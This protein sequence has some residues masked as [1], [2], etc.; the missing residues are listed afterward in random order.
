MSSWIPRLTGAWHWHTTRTYSPHFLSLCDRFILH[1][2]EGS[3]WPLSKFSSFLPSRLRLLWWWT[4]S[5][6]FSSVWKHSEE[7]LCLLWL[8][9]YAQKGMASHS[10]ILVWRMPRAEELRGLQSIGLQRGGQ[11]WSDLTCMH[12]VRKLG[13]STEM[14]LS[15]ELSVCSTRNSFSKGKEHC[16]QKKENSEVVK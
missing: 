10:T 16:S 2:A 1:K 12:I 5:S 15:L 14:Q 11:D 8:E 4:S 7:E 6:S 3:H 13:D 9:S